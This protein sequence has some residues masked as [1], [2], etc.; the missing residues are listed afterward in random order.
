M[1]TTSN[2]RAKDG[3]FKRELSFD[4][5][6]MKKSW[7]YIAILAVAV[8]VTT[9]W[10][11]ALIG[12][13][14]KSKLLQIV[15]SNGSARVSEVFGE[16]WAKIFFLEPYDLTLDRRLE[17]F[18]EAAR[19]YADDVPWEGDPNFWTIIVTYANRKPTVIRLSDS[20]QSQSRSSVLETGN[21]DAVVVTVPTTETDYNKKCAHHIAPRTCLRLE[22]PAN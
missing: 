9:A 15:E 17:I 6:Q 10:Q 18:G 8:L 2:M 12:S 22:S 13:E 7:L 3:T 4:N 19:E 1:M 16:G 11:W 20:E 5:G 21:R 14:Q